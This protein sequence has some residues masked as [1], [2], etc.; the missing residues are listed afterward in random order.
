[1]RSIRLWCLCIVA[2]TLFG[3]AG[4]TGALAEGL[5]ISEKS[6]FFAQRRDTL[7]VLVDLWPQHT[8][9]EALGAERDKVLLNTATFEAERL[10][11]RPGAE[12]VSKV[13]VEFG[14]IKNMDEYARQD[15]S[16]MVRHGY[17]VMHRQGSAAVVSE[18]KL[19][20][21]GEH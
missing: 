4:L 8:V 14:Y 20:F 12:Q 2:S 3:T 17:I 18:N 5:T 11:A 13:R 16:S 7:F 19:N 10:L 15:F 6:L 1:M 9:L 21:I